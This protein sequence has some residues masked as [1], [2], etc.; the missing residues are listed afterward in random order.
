MADVRFPA[1]L[2]VRAFFCEKLGISAE[3]DDAAK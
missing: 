2:G 1:D 3:E